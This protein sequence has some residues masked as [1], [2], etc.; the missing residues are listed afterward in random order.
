MKTDLIDKYLESYSQGKYTRL[1]LFTRLA[2]LV[3]EGNVSKLFTAIPQNL[4]SD[5]YSWILELSGD[6]E[7]IGG[8]AVVIIT[9]E[10]IAMLK[11]E[12]KR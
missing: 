8:E 10:Q 4:Q 7:S 12:A 3:S 9:K 5:F 1:E 2:G 6:C 11:E